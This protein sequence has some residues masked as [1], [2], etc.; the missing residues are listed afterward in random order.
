MAKSVSQQDFF[1]AT[2]IHYMAQVSTIVFDETPVDLFQNQHL[3]LQEHMQNP[4]A[5]HEE[6][7]DDIMYYH[8]SHQKLDA[9]QFAEAL[10]REVNGHMDNK[11]WELVKQDEVSEDTQVVLCMVHA[12]QVQPHH[13]QDH[14][15][16]G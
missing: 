6:M 16:Q 5:F 11:R 3:D 4:I 10:V 14:Q 2:G 12:T 8:Q 7:M 15:A 1:G 9:K 13:Q